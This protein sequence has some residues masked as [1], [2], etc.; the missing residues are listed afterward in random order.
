M[1]SVIAAALLA[2]ASRIE[3]HG[4]E[5]PDGRHDWNDQLVC[6]CGAW[7]DNAEAHAAHQAA[8]VLAA[9]SEAGT[10]EWGVDWPTPEHDYAPLWMSSKSSAETSAKFLAGITPD[11]NPAPVV[12]SRII[13]PWKPAE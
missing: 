11:R 10:V 8:A 5:R 9:I 2:H 4:T 7:P 6:A 3:E 1:V 13:F 12:V